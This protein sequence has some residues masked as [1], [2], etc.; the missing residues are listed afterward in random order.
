MSFDE[1][2]VEELDDGDESNRKPLILKEPGPCRCPLSVSEAATRQGISCQKVFENAF[3]GFGKPDF[4]ARGV[5]IAFISKPGSPVPTL[6]KKECERLNR[7]AC[8][9]PNGVTRRKFCM[10]CMLPKAEGGLF[11][12]YSMLMES[13][14]LE[15]RGRLVKPR[16]KNYAPTDHPALPSEDEPLQVTLE[17]LWETLQLSEALEEDDESLEELM[18]YDLEQ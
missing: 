13:H 4:Y 16:Q 18:R 17:R 15:E 5:F 3:E 8:Y 6:V 7:L 12:S 11:L 1:D 2:D 14:F 9:K 10:G